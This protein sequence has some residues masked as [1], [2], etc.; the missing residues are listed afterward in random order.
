[1]QV[2]RHLPTGETTHT[3]Q[4]AIGAGTGTGVGSVRAEALVSL[5][6]HGMYYSTELDE[7]L[8]LPAVYYNT[9]CQYTF[10]QCTNH[11]TS[12]QYQPYQYPLYQYTPNQY[13]LYQYT[14][15]QFTSYDTSSQSPIVLFACLLAYLLACLFVQVVSGEHLRRRPRRG[16][17]R[18]PEAGPIHPTNTPY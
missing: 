13:T 7:L 15:C 5:H 8:R 1:M 2:L 10:Y 14:P 18:G 17:R 12:Y 11:Y 3:A 9:S 4:S 6:E 16:G